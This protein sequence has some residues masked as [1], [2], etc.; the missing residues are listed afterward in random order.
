MALVLV[1]SLLLVFLVPVHANAKGNQSSVNCVI[2]L[3]SYLAPNAN[4]TCWVSPSGL[5]AFCFYPQDDGFAIGIW[6]VNQTVKSSGLQIE[7]T[8]L[9]LAMLH[10]T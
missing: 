1:L 6:L 7:M 8:H 10:R 2:H 9:S 4:R 5:F 3:A